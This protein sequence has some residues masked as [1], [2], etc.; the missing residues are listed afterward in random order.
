MTQAKEINAV[1]I[2]D[3]DA[4]RFNIRDAL[5]AHANWTIVG[6]ASNG[7]DG[8]T[9]IDN[10]NP[11]VVFLDIQM[12]FRDGLSLAQQLMKR[13]D[14]PI[15]VFV[16]AF[17][18][19]AVQA[20]ELYALDY[21]LKPFDT[22]RFAATIERVE[23]ALSFTST[24][25]N[26]RQRYRQYIE[27]SHIQRL[28]VRSA[29]SI[30]IINISDVYWFSTE[31][32]YVAVHHSKGVH[33]HR[34]SLSFL[35]QRLDPTVFIRTHRTAIV[36]IDQCVEIKTITEHKSIVALANG[37]EVNLSKTY[38]ELLLAHIEG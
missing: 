28:V 17:D 15:V 31:S 12:P 10:T 29:T 32:N 36:R 25:E 37:D 33:L 4:A 1:V 24:N 2:D 26:T 6:E 16:T 7:N 22:P 11:M 18:N 35:E 14:C 23:Q 30:R 9:L 38:R 5:N 20:F 3:E 19:Y 8:L 27:D 13:D 21:I 34:I